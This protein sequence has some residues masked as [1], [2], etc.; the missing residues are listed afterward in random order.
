MFPPTP[1]ITFGLP[2]VAQLIILLTIIV[3]LNFAVGVFRDGERLIYDRKFTAFASH[4]VWAIATALG[5]VPV[6]GIYWII[7]HST[8][9][10]ESSRP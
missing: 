10:R 4:W 5:G 8:L 9:R 1:S 2:F 3:H 6:A 7:H